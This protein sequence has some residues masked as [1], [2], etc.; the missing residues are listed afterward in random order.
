MVKISS[1]NVSVFRLQID[2]I[3]KMFFFPWEKES[4]HIIAIK[5]VFFQSP[6]FVD[7]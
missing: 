6:F 4:A 1:N 2:P 7:I 3:F 5:C